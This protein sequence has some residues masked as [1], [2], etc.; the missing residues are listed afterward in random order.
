LQRRGVVTT[1]TDGGVTWQANKRVTTA[2]SDETRAG[3]DQGNQYGD[4]QGS[5]VDSSGK[6]RLVWTDSRSNVTFEDIEEDSE[7]TDLPQRVTDFRRDWGILDNPVV[8][9]IP[10]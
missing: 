10:W 9:A 1:S 6:F 4:Y 8:F 2:Q 3:T 7:V 5:S